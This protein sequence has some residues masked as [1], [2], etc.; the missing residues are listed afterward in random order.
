MA[1]KSKVIVHDSDPDALARIKAFLDT[2]NLIGL[3]THTW[4]VVKTLNENVDLGAVLLSDSP[5]A[6]GVS[7]IDIAKRVHA[8]RRELPIFLRRTSK[9][10]D[11]NLPGDIKD[12]ISGTYS[13]TDMNEL[14]ALIE[15]Y[16]FA[17]YYPEKL[18][19]GIQEITE[20]ALQSTFKSSHVMTETPIVVRD[21]FIYGELF[22]LISLDSDWCRGY[23]MIQTDESAVAEVI[24]TGGT[25]LERTQ[26]DFRHV[27]SILSEVTNMV[28]GNVKSKFMRA[29]ETK[30][31]V[32]K[33]QVPIII[34]HARRFVSFGT[35]NPQLVLRYQVFGAQKQIEPISIIQ[36]FIFNLNWSPEKFNEDEKLVDDYL[37][38]GELE[39]L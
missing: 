38:S 37:S 17:Q 19:T 1:I 4:E 6:N 14:S 2:N 10:A 27:N 25:W 13:I 15:R 12:V 16:L 7:G 32:T 26:T 34:N 18:V 9:T 24:R 29:S 22:S 33:A 5:D 36:K 23:M 30:E 3:R 8:I 20:E 28:W 35:T 39:L 11:D 31:G 21:Q